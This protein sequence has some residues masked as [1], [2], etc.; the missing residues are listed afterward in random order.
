MATPKITPHLW[1]DNNAKEAAEFYVSAFPGSRVTSAGI[2]RDTPS[3]DC[4]IISF[5]LSGQPFMAINAGPLFK[6]NPSVSFMVNFDPSKDTA[7][8][9]HLDRLWEWLSN[10]GSVLMPLDA[11]PFSQ[12][13][14]W[15]QDKYGISWQLI[16]ANPDGD[17]RP[18]IIPALMFTRGVTGR[19]EEAIEFYC[20]VFKDSKRGAT[21]RYPKGMEPDQESIVMFADFFLGNTWLAAMDSGRAHDFTFNEAISLLIPCDSQAE[22]DNYWDK[23]SADPRAEQCG[24][25][26]DRFGLSWQVWP[27]AMGNMMSKGTPEQ[28]ARVTKAFL[29]MKKFDLAK[30]QQAYEGR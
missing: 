10:G 28:L 17:M 30:L 16:L 8:R 6:F 25:L 3:G 5:E 15:V 12:R 13:Y 19:A 21:V 29:A 23:L 20:S 22:I 24:W 11:Y 14:G 26:K 1:F 9:A 2:I 27:T 18:G 4:D 7:A